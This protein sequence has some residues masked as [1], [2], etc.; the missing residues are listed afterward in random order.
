MEYPTTPENE[1]CAAAEERD[2]RR[3]EIETSVRMQCLK[4]AI[5]KL[6]HN[7]ALDD[8]IKAAEK[9]ANFVLGDVPVTEF[10]KGVNAVID[11][12][13]R[14]IAVD[15]HCYINELMPAYRC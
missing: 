8:V 13:F 5:N 2:D 4:L 11:K 9:Y 10:E 1:C 15:S 6:A 3:D 7:A 12:R 14:K